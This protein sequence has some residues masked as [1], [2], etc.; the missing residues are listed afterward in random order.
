MEMPHSSNDN[1]QTSFMD[2]CTS[3]GSDS[4]C[5]AHFMEI[6]PDNGDRDDINAAENN[7][8]NVDDVIDTEIWDDVEDDFPQNRGNGEDSLPGVDVNVNSRCKA[9]NVLLS[10]CLVV[11]LA[12]FWTRFHIS[13]SGMEFLF[14]GL[15]KCF[16]MAAI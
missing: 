5:E 4:E 7:S 9:L 3:S 12:Y 6:P 15:K 1:C 13:D 14:S 16:E 8:V 11:L 10:R 2:F